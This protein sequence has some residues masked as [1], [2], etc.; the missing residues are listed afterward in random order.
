MQDQKIYL[1]LDIGTNSIG[2]A[3]TDARY[4]PL[5]YRGEPIMG[6]HLFEEASP[7]VDRRAARVARRR[8]ARRK[9]RIQLVQE[10]FAG[11]IAKVDERFFLRLKESFLYRDE[12]SDEG[13]LFSGDGISDQTYH[14]EFPTIHHLICSLMRDDPIKPHDVRLVYLA[15]AW[16]VKHR[17]H[18]LN[19]INAGSVEE[20]LDFGT[21]YDSF[22]DYF[23]GNELD[24]P[25]G[26]N[27]DRD[28]LRDLLK[29]KCG[30]TKKNKDLLGLLFNGKK[31][32][33]DPTG[34]YP[35]SVEKLLR[36][37]C[38]GK[39]ALKDLFLEKEE[40]A[41]LENSSVALGDPDETLQ[42]CFAAMDEMDAELIRVCKALYDW[43]LLAD[44]LGG[45]G[46]ISEAKVAV[47]ER[48]RQELK[49]LKRFVRTYL[50][51]QYDRFFRSV[52]RDSYAVYSGHIKEAAKE[53][54]GGTDDFIAALKKALKSISVREE[55]RQFYENMTERLE[56]N[57][58]LP[59]QVN[60]DNRV[61]PHQVYQFELDKILKNAGTYLP[62]LDRADETG[63]TVAEKI[64]S[65][66]TFRIPYYVGPL[67]ADGPHAWIARKAGRITPWNFDELVDRDESEQ[68]FIRRMTNTCTYFPGADV[69][70]KCSLLYQRFQVLN[71]INKIKIDGKPITVAQ[72]QGVYQL[73]LK[74][75]KVTRK[76][77]VEYLIAEGVL[78]R[79][80]EESLSGLDQTVKSS[81][82]SEH[83]F[84]RML[85]GGILT[86]EDAES[87]ILHGTYTE[88]RRRLGKWLHASF[89]ALSNED[90]SYLAH[91]SFKDFGRLSKEL[92]D[93]EL[94]GIDRKEGTGEAKSVIRAMWE[95][96]C[97]LMELLE[98]DRF[99]FPEQ[100]AEIRAE[101]MQ[102]H[103]KK[104]QERL[105]ELYLSPAVKRQVYRTLSVV[106]DV[107]K[108]VG[109]APDKL[110]VEMA[111]G[112]TPEQKGVRTKSRRRQLEEL[113]EKV[114]NEDVSDLR[115]SLDAM[116]D[117]ADN[118]LQS[119]KI[120]LYYLQLGKCMYSGE[121]IDLHKLMEKDC[122]LYNIE[123]IYP[124]S[125]VKDDSILNNKI[126]VLST[127]NGAKSDTYPVAK[128][129]QQKMRGMWQAYREKGLITEEKYRRL[130]RTTP[131][132]DD[133]KQGFINRQLTE[134]RQTT[135]AVLELLKEFYPE[136]EIVSVKAGLV[137][138]FR[139]QFDLLKSRQLNDLH[140][141]KDAY[142]NVVVGNVWHERFTK[143]FY[144]QQP[145]N[146]K[147]EKL[148]G[149]P[150]IA[151][152][153]TVWEGATSVETVRRIMQKNAIHYTVYPFRRGGA[154]FDLQPVKAAPGLVPLKNGL[155]PARYGGYNRPTASFFVL[156]RYRVGKKT[157]LMVMP[158]ELMVRERFLSDASFAE[159]YA[160]KTIGETASGKTVNE[161]SFPF[162]K[163]ILRV[164]T[165]LSLDGFRVCLS[166]KSNGGKQLIVSPVVPL[167]LSHEWEGYI[168]RL[169]RFAEKQKK[170]LG[171]TLDAEHDGILAEKNRELY[172]LL[173][174][175][176][177]QPPFRKRPNNPAETLAAG[178]DRFCR[179]SVGEQV[180]ALL[181]VLLVFSRTGG[182][183]DLHLVGGK[184][185]AAA[186]LLS[187]NLS[188]WK[189]N[190]SDVRVIDATSSGLFEK[191][192]ENLLELL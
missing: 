59:L 117:L 95:T 8:I 23:K 43:A 51:D 184:P 101:Y 170:K 129:I 166:G 160:K 79:G 119:D 139:Q 13:S 34:S 141:A 12:A 14:R 31:P 182:G 187:S 148:F 173:T 66:F 17:G 33:E 131:F 24:L 65:V 167:I 180:E 123:H 47:Y 1:G 99:T 149:N 93:G 188:N 38:G 126:L 174:Q 190:Y 32:T 109:K 163:R 124:Q 61:I 127:I 102:D 143:H 162:G 178:A 152:G 138:E 100:L 40:Y 73:F 103:P 81:L 76:K 91:R 94:L 137:S 105:S 150:V 108:A 69:L 62:F 161:V 191:R 52:T 153:E 64:L 118:R 29:Q 120:F 154:L 57:D 130:I 116:G 7:A 185:K 75:R 78:T 168:K 19:E 122:S 110:F 175:K 172:A 96:N 9:F 104:L 68:A 121:T 89:P 20:I 46:S 45:Y 125:Q 56:N 10:L 179:L 183:I 44:L 156:V 21:V 107:V 158:V 88:D 36:L 134:T 112:G 4:I 74:H 157:D 169:E 16:L 70:P 83:D 71:E 41:D 25:W 135:K 22:L 28:M 189:K 113:Y 30:I 92:L 37:L 140:H 39:V 181:S 72:K 132:T 35:F 128:E 171:V 136:S 15:C 147:T 177:Q 63:K 82:S 54:D 186:T 144:L 87:I 146:L 27:V 155:D 176:L 114:Q 145:Y 106:S 42:A 50:P 48:H 11:E 18:F 55:D 6:T 151:N 5:K 84:K 67:R 115:Q 98:G 26:E 165:V 86:R 60:S 49:E 58:F 133:E 164:N 80:C 97:N 85:D 142:L 111:R 77:I 159:E 192:S 2:Y 90:V 3:A 53:K